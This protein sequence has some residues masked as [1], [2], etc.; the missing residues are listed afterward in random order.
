MGAARK[1]GSLQKKRRSYH[2]KED[3]NSDVYS[4][5]KKRTH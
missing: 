2:S 4:R 5:N 3:E 1:P